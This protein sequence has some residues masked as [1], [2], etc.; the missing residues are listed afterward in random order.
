MASDGDEWT[1][2]FAPRAA[3]QFDTLEHPV[4]ECIVSKLD[5]TIDDP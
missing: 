5:R 4:Q 3:K 2:K 1:G